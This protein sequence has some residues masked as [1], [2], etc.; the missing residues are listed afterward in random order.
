ML[1]WSR[2]RELDEQYTLGGVR[3]SLQLLAD[4]GRLPAE[5]VDSLANMLLAAVGEAALLIVRARRPRGGARRPAWRPSTLCSTAS[6]GQT[7]RVRKLVLLAAVALLAGCTVPR[8]PGDSPLRYRDLVFGSV[9]K[10]ADIQYGSAPDLQGN[11]VAL[12]LDLYQPAGTRT[13]A[14]R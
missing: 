1:G 6:L 13:R 14:G 8:P 9:G 7:R 5:Q 12:K 4:E 10:S 3:R 2:W 11:P